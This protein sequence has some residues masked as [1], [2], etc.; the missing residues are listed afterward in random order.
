MRKRILYVGHFPP[1]IHGVAVINEWIKSSQKING[2]FD[3]TFINISLSK[4]VTSLRKFSFSKLFNVFATLIR[5]VRQTYFSKYNLIVYNNAPL[6]IAFWR[7]SFYSIAIKIA[8]PSK[9]ELVF[10][11]HGK[12]F[13]E[14]SLN[15]AAYRFFARKMFQ[16]TS[17]VCL[18][19]LL[20][21]EYEYF[22]IKRISILPNG[23]PSEVKTRKETVN[24][25]TTFLF[26]SNFFKSKGILDFVEAVISLNEKQPRSEF[27]F[28][29]VGYDFDVSKEEIILMLE[30]KNIRNRLDFI[31][32]L[33]GSSKQEAILNSN[34]LVLPTYND[35]FPLV[36]LEAF[37]YGTP[38]ISTQ[39][40]AIPEII[41]NGL[42]GFCLPPGER[43]ELIKSMEFFLENPEQIKFF[44]IEAQKKFLTHYQFAVFE[45]HFI[46]VFDSL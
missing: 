39:V 31:G 43:G 18:S 26:L 1:P 23:I 10:Y 42:S 27:R 17:V 41:D 8:K 9:T 13:K 30:S 3:L 32:P 44:G 36:I 24:Q 29:I 22:Q 5:V 14:Y 33:M 15:S 11:V 4:D 21:K 40:G 16:N 28:K 34:V 2:Y 46:E 35:C 20:A 6:G 7:D 45:Q 25:H 19:Q 38:V 12:G 37:S